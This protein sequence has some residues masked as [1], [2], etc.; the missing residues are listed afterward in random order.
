MKKLAGITIIVLLISLSINAQQKNRP[1]KKGSDFTPEQVATL[2]VK[3][4][5][6]DLDLNASQQKE[7]YTIMKSN[8]EERKTQMEE[9]KQNRE[10][11]VKLTSDEK[12]EMQVARLDKQI[13]QR[14]AIKNILSKD[15]F[16]EWEEIMK[17]RKKDGKKQMAQNNQRGGKKGNQQ[18]GINNNRG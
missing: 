17:S 16:V 7:M 11:G 14:T 2:K 4:M 5:T 3:Q 9:R 10:A 6:L 8:A 12:Y 1:Q 13:I 18:N 15:Q